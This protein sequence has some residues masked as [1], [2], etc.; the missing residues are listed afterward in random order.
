MTLRLLQIP[1][2]LLHFEKIAEVD[3][4]IVFRVGFLASLLYFI[5]FLHKPKRLEKN[6][7]LSNMYENCK[8]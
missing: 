7:Q 4:L 5:Y 2:G 3:L 1:V 8:K 6:I